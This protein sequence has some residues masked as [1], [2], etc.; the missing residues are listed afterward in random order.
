MKKIF[1]VAIA[2]ILAI[3]AMTSCC[4]KGQCCGSDSCDADT[5]LSK[6]LSDSVSIAQGTYIGDAILSNM[7]QINRDGDINKQDLLKGIQLI[8]GADD[9]K[10]N[11]IGMQFGIQMLNEIKQMEEMGIKVDRKLML[12]S[13][14]KAFLQ[15][16]IDQQEAQHAFGV[17]QRLLNTAQAE[18]K[19]KEEARI[20]ASPEAKQNVINGDEF[21]AGVLSAEPAIKTT[22]SGLSYLII[23]EGQGDKITD[24]NRLKIKYTERKVNGETVVETPEAGRLT[25]LNNVTPGFAEGLKMLAQ[26]GKAIFYVPGAIAYGVAGV[27]SRNVGPNELIIYEAEVIEVQ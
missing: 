2:A 23:N 15:D 27:P 21:L 10:A 13:F 20:A 7:P 1:P 18:I 5:T 25:Y 19:A 9:S 16:S 14:K 4:G 22:D 26:G 17:F 8:F 12:E 11:Q 24:K 3:G 6:E